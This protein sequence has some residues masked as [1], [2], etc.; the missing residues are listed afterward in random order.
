MQQTELAS[1]VGVGFQLLKPQNAVHLLPHNW[2]KVGRN[3]AA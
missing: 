3:W 2:S 1:N